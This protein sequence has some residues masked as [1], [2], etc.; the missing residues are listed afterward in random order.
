MRYPVFPYFSVALVMGV[1]L[2]ILGPSV[3]HLEGKLGVSTSMMSLLFA[4]GAGCNLV[5]ALVSGRFMNRFGGHHLLIVGVFGIGIGVLLICVGSLFAVVALGMSMAGAGS[6]L[7]D[8]GVNTL[9]VWARAG[10]AGPSLNALH[11]MFGVGAFLAP[12][13]VDRSLAWVGGLWPTAVFVAILL[14]VSFSM[15]VTHD[16]PPHPDAAQVEVRPHIPR[17]AV[18][19]VALF[20]LLYV[21]AEVAFGGWIHT[22]AEDVGLEGS[23]PALVTA[24]FWAAFSLGR[25][26]AIP[27]SSRIR[28][29]PLV[30]GACAL[31]VVGLVIIVVGRGDQ[32]AVWTGTALYGL[33]SGPQ[34]PTML[35]LVDSRLSL[36]P[37][38]TGY[39]VAAAGLGALVF[40]TVVGPLLD[41]VGS[42][43]MPAL[44]L[45]V[46]ASAAVW[47]LMVRRAVNRAS[48]LSRTDVLRPA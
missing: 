18:A 38:A 1:G 4:V 22:Y 48:A 21:G 13:S 28:P 34:Y 32:S 14:T 45:T 30:S 20:F 8:T 47:V 40:P 33:S 26:V 15:L 24:V 16:E 17:G 36:T 41:R 11:L 35:A 7:A 43:A 12:L 2:S 42:G 39:I 9:T 3:S 29:L 23:R 37:T 27:V 31:S 25:L 10:E 19:V 5:G 6:A 44:V 46:T